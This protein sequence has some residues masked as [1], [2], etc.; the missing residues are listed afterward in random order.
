MNDIYFPILMALQPVLV[1]MRGYSYFEA[2]LLPVVHCL[3]SAILQP[4][5]GRLS[6]RHGWKLPLWISVFL[7]GTGIAVLGLVSDHYLVMLGCVA[8]SAVGHAGFHIRAFYQV[9][10]LSASGSR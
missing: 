3:L 9:H 7:S 2:A 1:T 10:A 4:V 8:L 6:D 5:F